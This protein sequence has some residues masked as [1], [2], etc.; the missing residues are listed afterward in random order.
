MMR[1]STE[2]LM[3]QVDDFTTFVEELKDYSW[4]LSKKESF[5]LER[6][7][8]FQKELVIDVPFIQLVEEAEDCHMEVVVALFDQTWLIKESMR[9]QEEI[10][11]ISFSEE[12]IVDGRIETL[13]NDQ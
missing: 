4:R 6:V 5:F 13:E 12:E 10:L 2:D 1:F 9:V 7:L 8:R 11:A 3:E